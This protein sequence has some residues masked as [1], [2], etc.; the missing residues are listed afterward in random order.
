MFL[1]DN[2]YIMDNEE[3]VGKFLAVYFRAVEKLREDANQLVPA[4]QKFLKSYTGRDF[5]E[6]I[7]LKDLKDLYDR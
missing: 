5:S 1:A 2:K 7:C 6:T 3:T 4:Y